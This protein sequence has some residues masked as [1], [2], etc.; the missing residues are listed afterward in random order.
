[1]SN[2]EPNLIKLLQAKDHKSEHE[3]TSA[4]GSR[5]WASCSTKNI[6]NLHKRKHQ[7][8]GA[9]S[10]QIAAV[11]ITQS[12]AWKDV[13]NREPNLIKPLHQTH[14][15]GGRGMTSAMG[16]RIWSSCCTE[17]KI[18]TL[19]N[20]NNR[21]PNAIKILYKNL[22]SSA[23]KTPSSIGSRICQAAVLKIKQI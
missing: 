21:E 11:E 17:N 16:S 14:H 9:E 5:T 2:R 22:Y 10:N 8:W 23:Q 3:K 1:M 19:E 7:K 4:I 12:C 13:G 15:K 6:A 18:G 20:I